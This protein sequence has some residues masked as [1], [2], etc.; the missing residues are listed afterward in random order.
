MQV[1][2]LSIPFFAKVLAFTTAAELERAA[3][4]VADT[5][6]YVVRAPPPAVCPPRLSVCVVSCC[7]VL[8]AS[9]A[10]GQHV[11]DAPVDEHGRVALQLPHRHGLQCSARARRQPRE[12][13]GAKEI[14]LG[15]AHAVHAMHAR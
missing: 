2:V 1:S 8:G 14:S 15:G 12:G 6:A 10:S 11:A 4:A 9:P 7:A 13:G 5:P 3:S